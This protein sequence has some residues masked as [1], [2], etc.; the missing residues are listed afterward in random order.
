MVKEGTYLDGG[1]LD[2]MYLRKSFPVIAV[3]VVKNIYSSDHDA[4]KMQ[5]P[6]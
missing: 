1:L 3:A 6:M 5:L 4:V 2:H